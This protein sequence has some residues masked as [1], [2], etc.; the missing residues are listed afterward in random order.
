MREVGYYWVKLEGI[1]TI[2]MWHITECRGVRE[3][4]WDWFTDQ[5]YKDKDFDEI[6]EQMIVRK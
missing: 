3:G 6:D 4:S 2:A 5:C 1:W